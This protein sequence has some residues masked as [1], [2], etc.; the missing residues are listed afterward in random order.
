M[1]LLGNSLCMGKQQFRDLAAVPYWKEQQG[2]DKPYDVAY[3][4]RTCF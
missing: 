1:T 2:G 3:L 4:L